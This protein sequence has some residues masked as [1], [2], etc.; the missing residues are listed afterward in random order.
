MD[1]QWVKNTH[2][3]ILSLISLKLISIVI[4]QSSSTDDTGQFI[5]LKVYLLLSLLVAPT[6]TKYILMK[7]SVSCNHVKQILF[8]HKWN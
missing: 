6:K 7:C 1:Q 4:K 3:P 5:Q 8:L 2:K